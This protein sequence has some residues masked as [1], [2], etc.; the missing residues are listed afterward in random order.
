MM[1]KI[2][3]LDR[4]LIANFV[5][6]FIVTFMIAIP[7]LINLKRKVPLDNVRIVSYSGTVAKFLVDDNLGR[8]F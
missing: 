3:K 1:L 6:P 8:Y 2:K 7:I 4:L 5:G